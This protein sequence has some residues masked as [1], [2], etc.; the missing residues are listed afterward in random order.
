MKS[1]DNTLD[2]VRYLD[3]VKMMRNNINL[4]VLIMLFFIGIIASDRFLT[5]G[6]MINVFT[7]ISIN[8]VLAAGFTIVCLSGGFDL[9]LGSTVSVAAV[10]FMGI[11]RTNDIWLAIA[12]SLIAGACFGLLNGVLLKVVRGDL[13]DTFLITLGTALLGRSI[14][15]TYA[16]GFNIFADNFGP[17]FR[18]IGSGRVLGIPIQIIIMLSVMAILQFMLK[19]TEF[20]RNIYLIGGNK[21]ASYMSGINVHKVKTIAFI[22]AGIC[23]VIAAIILT[24][25]TTAASP[26]SGFGYEFNAAIAAVIGGNR[27]GGGRGGIVHT[28]IGVIILGFLT[29]IMNLMNIATILQMIIKG[30]MLVLALM[31]DNLRTQS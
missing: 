5:T 27:V 30:I 19:K 13:G 26:R 6:N 11:Q 7:Q 15:H 31:A 23:A 4:M 17:V 18:F 12:I 29:N 2:S 21:T 14:A 10:L 20:G 1:R 9:S 22:I 24:S 16:G 28:L 25:R 3:P 8:G